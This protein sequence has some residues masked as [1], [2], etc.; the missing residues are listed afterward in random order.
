MRVKIQFETKLPVVFKEEENY[1]IACCPILDVISQGDDK[2]K[3]KKNLSEALFLFFI[4]CYEKGTLDEVMKDCGFTFSP[5]VH[6][7]EDDPE[8]ELLEVKIPFVSPEYNNSECH[9]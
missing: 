2:E 6:V 7:D 9:V 8:Q 4:T 5:D 1:V 3:A